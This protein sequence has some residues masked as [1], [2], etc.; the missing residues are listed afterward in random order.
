MLNLYAAHLECAA[1]LGC[2]MEFK[3][4]TNRL[5]R[6]LISEKIFTVEVQKVLIH[7]N[8][9]NGTLKDQDELVHVVADGLENVDVSPIDFA[10]GT[11]I[12]LNAKNY[13]IENMEEV[14][15]DMKKEGVELFIDTR[16]CIQRLGCGNEI[17]I[18]FIS[19]EKLDQFSIPKSP[20]MS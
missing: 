10:N 8:K 15:S 16:G 9:F 3:T 12:F 14:I 4:I 5:G 6:L 11:A 1:N 13:L 20:S 7:F 2:N 17:D 19:N 18:A